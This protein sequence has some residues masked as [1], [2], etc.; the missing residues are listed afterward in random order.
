MYLVFG[1]ALR[2]V[3]TG[4]VSVSIYRIVKTGSIPPII[5]FSILSWTLFLIVSSGASAYSRFR[6]PMVPLEALIIAYG[7]SQLK[8]DAQTRVLIKFKELK[9]IQSAR[10]N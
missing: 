1:M 2:V 7:I 3:A 6:V 8:S 9:F 10:S 5:L 4:L